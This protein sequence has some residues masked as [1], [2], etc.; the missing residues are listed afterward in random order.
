MLFFLKLLSTDWTE[1]SKFSLYVMR[2]PFSPWSVSTSDFMQPNTS[3]GELESSPA[4]DFLHYW[5]ILLSFFSAIYI[6][7]QHYSSSSQFKEQTAPLL[8]LPHHT[9]YRLQPLLALSSKTLPLFSNQNIKSI[10]SGLVT[11]LPLL[12]WAPSPPSSLSSLPLAL[13]ARVSALV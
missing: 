5:F 8:Y 7:K 13:L 4:N 1:S 10:H 12:F 2:S 11:C 6:A 3:E 9:A